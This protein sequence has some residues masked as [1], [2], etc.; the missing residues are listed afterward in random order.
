M[1]RSKF[2]FE[3]VGTKIEKKYWTMFIQIKTRSQ[4]NKKLF[5]RKWLKLI[6]ECNEIE[7]EHKGKRILNKNKK[8][9]RRT[10]G[11]AF[12]RRQ[13]SLIEIQLLLLDNRVSQRSQRSSICPQE[14]HSDES[15]D[16]GG[17]IHTNRSFLSLREKESP[18]PCQPRFPLPLSFPPSPFPPPC[19]LPPLLF[20]DNF[21][22]S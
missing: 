14:F 16:D 5:G 19:P 17:E 1:K 18:H 11:R 12:D 7:I 8:G 4:R 21:W 15:I 20:S 13:D 9:E 6:N 22:S 2:F 10:A 3:D